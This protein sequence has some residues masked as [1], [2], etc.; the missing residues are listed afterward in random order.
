M[1]TTVYEQCQGGMILLRN[2]DA[3]LLPIRQRLRVLRQKSVAGRVLELA[4]DGVAW[5]MS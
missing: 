3:G 1:I 4:G 2:Y 5:G